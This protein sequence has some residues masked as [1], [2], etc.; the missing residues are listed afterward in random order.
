[1]WL[2]LTD[3]PLFL[4]GNSFEPSTISPNDKLCWTSTKKAK[5]PIAAPANI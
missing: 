5:A 4:E 3:I 2:P 1:M